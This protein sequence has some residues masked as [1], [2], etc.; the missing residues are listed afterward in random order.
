[1]IVEVQYSL[2]QSLDFAE[3]AANAC[4]PLNDWIGTQVASDTWVSFADK[5]FHTI[6][7]QLTHFQ[8]CWSIGTWFDPG[9]F[10]VYLKVRQV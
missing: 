3:D 6:R 10:S 4:V 7:R 5:A 1:M 9:F 8:N 2:F